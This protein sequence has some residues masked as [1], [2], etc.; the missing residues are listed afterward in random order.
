M[1]HP[2]VARRDLS[3]LRC[4]THVGASA[5]PTLR[6][7]ARARLGPV[8]A[9]TYGASEMG[10]ISV[11]PPSGHDISDAE[12]FGSA[13]PIL[14]GVE[15][16]F[17]RGEGGLA[18]P[19]EGGSVEVRSPA[20]ASG[21]LN[22]PDLDAAAFHDGWYRSGDLRL[23]DAAG[24]LHTLGRAVDALSVDG[25]TLTP[26]MVE[27]TLCG[28]TSVRYAVVV[29]NC[30]PRPGPRLWRRGRRTPWMSSPASERSMPSMVPAWR[31]EFGSSQC[32]GSRA[33]SS[34]SQTGR[35]FAPS[36]GLARTAL[37]EP[38]P[39]EMKRVRAPLLA[40]AASA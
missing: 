33:R 18:A 1:D 12:S 13:G 15:V 10:L 14:P 4:L 39:T 23:L 24:R 16:R 26:T 20:M 40:A 27:D 34:A 35:Q 21:Y 2:D 3:S 17:R 5:P 28:V 38:A 32:R 30:G 37:D 25:R 6:R 31:R 22:R 29:T 19:E 36:R 9:H 7:Q 11:L 8:V